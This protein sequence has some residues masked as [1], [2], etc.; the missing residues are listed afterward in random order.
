[1]S[2]VEQVDSW[3]FKVV[4]ENRPYAIY[5]DEDTGMEY[6]R[7]PKSRLVTTFDHAFNRIE[8]ERLN[9]A[10]MG[11]HTVVKSSAT[12]DC[13]K[14]YTTAS[15]DGETVVLYDDK[16]KT[17]TV[18]REEIWVNGDYLWLKELIV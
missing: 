16:G 3:W 13:Y 5:V 18:P 10:R 12:L 8:K 14:L 9:G 11:L 6:E 15:L 17:I 7:K 1:M 4:R 2:G